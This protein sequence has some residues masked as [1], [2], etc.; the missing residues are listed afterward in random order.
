MKA[1]AVARERRSSYAT[2]GPRTTVHTDRIAR[3]TR[4]RRHGGP[5]NGDQY[6]LLAKTTLV[7]TKLL[8][9][10]VVL[11]RLY[12]LPKADLL[13]VLVVAT[14]GFSTVSTMAWMSR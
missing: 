8:G 4:C 9:A 7:V 12:D 13:G 11:T 3:S 10:V 5:M 14:M 6:E 1:I 2:T